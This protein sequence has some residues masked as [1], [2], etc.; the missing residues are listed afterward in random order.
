M[1]ALALLSFVQPD[2]SVVN[3]AA[4]MTADPCTCFLE[5]VAAVGVGYS[6]LPSA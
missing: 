6:Y 3:F 1:I 2:S 5:V 4:F